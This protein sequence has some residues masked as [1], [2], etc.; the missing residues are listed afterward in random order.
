MSAT[1]DVA[2]SSGPWLALMAMA[3]AWP[4]ANLLHN[5]WSMLILNDL[6]RAAWWW[7]AIFA[8][9]CVLAAM[10]AGAV[11]RWT[12]A[13]CALGAG[14][15]LVAF[16]LFEWAV[17]HSATALSL[18]GLPRRAA[19]VIYPALAIVLVLAVVRLAASVPGRKV[20]AT[21][22]AVGSGSSLALLA[23]DMLRT[24]VPLGSGQAAQPL[25]SAS[26]T[27][28]RRPNV[29]MIVLDGYARSDVLF[30]IAGFDATPFV[31][32]LRERGFT[33]L[34]R[35]V[36]NYPVTYLSVSSTLAADYL[37]TPEHGPYLNRAG[38]YDV[39]RGNNRVV[40][41][42]R[43]LGYAYV[44]SGNFW[45]GSSCSGGEDVCLNA[46]DPAHAREID[47]NIM[48]MTPFRLFLPLVASTER[49][50][51]PFITGNLD[52]IYLKTP[53]FFFGHT[54]PPHPPFERSADCSRKK[55]VARVEFWSDPHEYRDNLMCVNSQILQLVDA[56][57]ARDP[58]AVL[59]L[60]SDHGTAFLKPFDS[61]LE[62][63]SDAMITERFPTFMAIRAPARCNSVLPNSL[64]NVNVGRFLVACAA[65]SALEYRPDRFFT[66]TYERHAG[67]GE[68][69]E[70]THRIE[71][72]R[73]R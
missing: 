12:F 43:A 3:A 2:R 9:T 60:L 28:E 34:D 47:I 44:H 59:V 39:M 1:A 51:L 63:W 72:L 50:N 70:I 35:S 5:N 67:F 26:A 38:F 66:S 40:A 25:V 32:A 62:E 14:V 21:F 6:W 22:L 64:S 55:H 31:R 46:L 30:R 56:V 24:G 13:Q 69:R 11:R 20:V 36:A 68:V 41:S 7:A 48:L 61:G 54:I 52:A 57:V 27:P 17:S 29:F 42:F 18:V 8:T 65:G 49:G 33:V 16:F 37:A 71:S 45:S 23:A 4:I 10:A 15:G 58:E 73:L 53:V 19:N